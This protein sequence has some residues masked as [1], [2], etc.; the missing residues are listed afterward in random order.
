[1]ARVQ[2]ADGK[3]PWSGTWYAHADDLPLLERLERGEAWEPRTVLLS[4]F[5]N[6]ICDRKRTQTLFN[7]DFTMEIYVPKEK[8]RWGYYVLP[9]LH[10][11]QLI[12][13][14]DPATDRAKGILNVHALH[15][16]P[17]APLNRAT[18]RAIGDAL[19]HLA[20]F[21]GARDIAHTTP[22]PAKWGLD[23]PATPRV[24]QTARR[25][26]S[27]RAPRRIAKGVAMSPIASHPSWSPSP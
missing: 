8:R 11:D 6:L 2:I 10:G 26:F 24:T 20:R 5:D 18:G 7:F 27:Q 17:D 15:A 9:I 22:G 3:G 13:K 16:E 21:V 4:P 19:E 1:M 14:V 12:G 25:S 23:A